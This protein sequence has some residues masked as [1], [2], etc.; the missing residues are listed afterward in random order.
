V[1]SKDLSVRLK[2]WTQ[3]SKRNRALDLID[4]KTFEFLFVQPS[5]ILYTSQI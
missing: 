2:S 3:N 4:Q 5:G 1:L